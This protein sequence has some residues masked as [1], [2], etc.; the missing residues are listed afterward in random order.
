VSEGTGPLGASVSG[1]T[2][3]LEPGLSSQ[4]IAGGPGEGGA[5]AS[6]G[7]EEAGAG[8]S[9]GMGAGAGAKGGRGVA[10]HQRRPRGWP[11]QTWLRGRGAWRS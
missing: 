4:G 2:V 5:T 8:G 6:G 10:V 11:S 7:A 9:T 3:K 1:P